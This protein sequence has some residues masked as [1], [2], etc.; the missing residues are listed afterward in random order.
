MSPLSVTSSLATWGSERFMSEPWT[1]NRWKHDSA[2]GDAYMTWPEAS[3]R[4]TPSPTRG[5]PRRGPVTDVCTG[6]SPR[7]HHA[8]DVIGGALVVEL[9]AARRPRHRLGHLSRE[10][11]NRPPVHHHREGVLAHR[12]R[13]VPPRLSRGDDSALV[14][15]PLKVRNAADAAMRAN[16]VVQVHGGPVDGR[17]CAI[18]TNPSSTARHRMRSAKDKVGDDLPVSDERREPLGLFVR[19]RAVAFGGLSQGGHTL[20]LRRGTR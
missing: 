16:D 5:A 15:R 19:E 1:P 20:S 11:A 8:Q 10:H 3:R 14:E 2:F 18:A 9:Q 13:V 6:Y 12:V 7:R 17:H 4:S